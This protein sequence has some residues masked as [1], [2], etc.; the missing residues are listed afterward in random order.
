MAQPKIHGESYPPTKEYR[1]WMDI[2]RRCVLKSNGQYWKYGGRGI[3]MCEEWQLSFQRFL[4]DMGR[5]P[6]GRGRY[7][8]D[9]IDSAKGYSKENCR[10]ATY[11][12]QENNRPSFNRVISFG[13]KTMT[14]AMW[15]RELG[16]TRFCLFARLKRWT[17]EKALTYAKE[18]TVRAA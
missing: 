1:T 11:L 4:A 10:W 13:G 18:E 15:A 14:T 5:A 6:V 2:R 9:R 3:G 16:I 8:I 7:T 17:I 12:E